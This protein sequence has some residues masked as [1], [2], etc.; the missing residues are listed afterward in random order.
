MIDYEELKSASLQPVRSD[1]GEADEED[2]EEVD[3][4]DEADESDDDDIDRD[5]LSIFMS[6]V[7]T[8]TISVAAAPDMNQVEIAS[9]T[10]IEIPEEQLE[11]QAAEESPEE[12]VTAEEAAT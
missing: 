8:G 9:A 5:V 10:S 2:A 6:S 3:E 4:T 1:D 11:E 12:A 7:E